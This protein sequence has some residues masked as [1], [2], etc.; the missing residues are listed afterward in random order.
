MLEDVNLPTIMLAA[1][2]TTSSPGPATLGIA[3]TSM[4]AG[5]KH[6]LALASGITTGSL[7]W[8]IGAALGLGA[9]MMANAWVL[10]AMRYAGA[11]YLLF[12]AF[13]SARGALKPGDAVTA[14]MA[15]AT[16][17]RTFLK[18]LMLHLTNPKAIFFFVAL[19][20]IGVPHGTPASTLA[21]VIAAVGIQ[22]FVIFH[23]YALLF[24][25]P[26]IARVYAHLRR[27]FDAT[28]ACVFGYAGLKVLAARLN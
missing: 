11:A 15:G 23:G 3:G 5:R 27:W 17:G 1:L 24:S 9:A 12:L 8:S 19:Y 2:V 20:A 18:G 7:C 25:R 6:G 28:F 10:E 14:A 4:V 13:K 26:A 22:S 21:V 16:P